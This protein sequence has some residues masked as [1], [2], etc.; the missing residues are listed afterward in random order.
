MRFQIQ[1]KL[2]FS[3]DIS[4][5]WDG[6]QFGLDWFFGFYDLGK[7]QK[8]PSSQMIFVKVFGDDF[9]FEILTFQGDM[10]SPFLEVLFEPDGV[11]YGEGCWHF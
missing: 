1:E 8:H 6:D 7:F 2:M 4:F 10:F 3:I 5:G 9:L 11:F